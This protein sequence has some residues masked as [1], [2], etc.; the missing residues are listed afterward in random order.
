MYSKK[1]MIYFVPSWCTS[2]ILRLIEQCLLRVM[3][4]FYINMALVL[5]GCLFAQITKLLKGYIHNISYPCG[6]HLQ[7]L[8]ID[9]N[10]PNLKG[11]GSQRWG[12]HRCGFFV[13]N[14]RSRCLEKL[15]AG[16]TEQQTS[17]GT[18]SSKWTETSSW[19]QLGN[20][21]KT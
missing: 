9:S 11:Y 4:C 6:E 18:T 8:R 10:K 15:Q 12:R 14:R 2:E 7:R 5:C 13:R 17:K 3:F 19:Q 16:H 20:P 21:A 1:F